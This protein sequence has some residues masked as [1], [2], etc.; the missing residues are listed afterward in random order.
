MSALFALDW[1]GGSVEAAFRR[2]RPGIDGLPWDRFRPD[3]LPPVL[4]DRA[5]LA[6]TDGAFGEY[7]TAGQLA[8]L[9]E[10]LVRVRAPVDLIGAAGAFVADEM[11]HVELHA[12]V[13]EGLGGAAPYLV[14]DA[15]LTAPI[16]VDEPPLRA[17]VAAAIRTC[18]VGEAL[19]VAILAANR[20]AVR[21][22]L[23]VEV[24]SRLAADEAPHAQLGS[25]ILDWAGPRLTDADR[26]ALSQVAAAAIADVRALADTPSSTQGDGFTSEGF[27]VADLRALGWIDSA[28]WAAIARTTLAERIV[29]RLQAAGLDLQGANTSRLTAP[30]ATSAG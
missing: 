30:A 14:H 20:K 29:P 23:L 18:C 12:R 9:L 21:D 16:P 17:V 13:L 27:A 15:L 7:A 11:V 4:V 2:S 10:G 19:S 8:G 6:W 24:F 26:A 1:A 28:A 3:G 25:W 5:R 22:P